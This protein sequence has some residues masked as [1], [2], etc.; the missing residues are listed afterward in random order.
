VTDKQ[1]LNN[2][3]SLGGVLVHWIDKLTE[4]QKLNIFGSL[5]GTQ[6]LSPTKLGTQ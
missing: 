6:S 1:K 3:G 4:K 2:F 5:G